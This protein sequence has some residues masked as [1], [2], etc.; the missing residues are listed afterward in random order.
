[1][2]V[3]GTKEA[4]K[5]SAAEASKKIYGG[6]ACSERGSQKDPGWQSFN[7]DIPM[8]GMNLDG[9]TSA[10]KSG[11]KCAHSDFTGPD[12]TA[13]IDNQHWRLLGCTKAYQP[14]G[15]MDR[16]WESGNFIKEGIPMLVD[17]PRPQQAAKLA[18]GSWRSRAEGQYVEQTP[19]RRAE[20]QD[21]KLAAAKQ[22]ATAAAE[23]RMRS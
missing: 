1:M 17:T 20:L 11:G 8:A 16:M 19:R 12:G 3:E 10:A 9:K 6:D 4:K 23:D 21:N 15:Q 22:V 7:G 13:G 5:T 2:M 14:Q 18:T